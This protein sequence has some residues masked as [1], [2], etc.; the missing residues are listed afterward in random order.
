MEECGKTGTTRM[1]NNFETH[2]YDEFVTNLNTIVKKS[3]KTLSKKP[4]RNVYLAG[5][6]FD[7]RAER[8]YDAVLNIINN[9]TN[10]T[11]MKFFIP[12][13]QQSES[14]RKVFANN[15]SAVKKCDMIIAL[16]SRKDVGTAWEIG[17]GYALGKQIV[18]LGY[19]ETTFLSKTNLML[20]FCGKCLT[21]DKLSKFIEYDGNISLRS[22]TKIKNVWEGIE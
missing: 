1:P 12:K 13:N 9:A 4:I 20:A 16:V 15:V 7:V 17:M 18:L 6:W 8:L 10:H 21:L 3:S 19:D 5:P 22:F 2:Q 11:S 14:P